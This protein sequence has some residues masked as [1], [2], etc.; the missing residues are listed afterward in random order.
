[1]QKKICK[2]DF[3]LNISIICK[4]CCC[5]DLAHYKNRP[6][7]VWSIFISQEPPAKIT[8]VAI[9][10]ITKKEPAKRVSFLHKA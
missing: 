7:Y 1:M 8:T 9:A 4:N 2:A 10:P 6:H 3:L 5:S